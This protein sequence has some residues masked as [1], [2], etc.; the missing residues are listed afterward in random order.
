MELIE[1][2]VFFFFPQAVF[3]WFCRKVGSEVSFARHCADQ[4]LRALAYCHL[5]SVYIA[6]HR[7]RNGPLNSRSEDF[8]QGF[9]L[10]LGLVSLRNLHRY[11]ALKVC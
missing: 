4:I 2:S 5:E 3:S 11:S 10:R 7:S 1:F 9:R 6:S 8:F